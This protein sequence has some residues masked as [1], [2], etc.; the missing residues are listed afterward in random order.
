ML[1]IWQ[2]NQETLLF[3]KGLNLI[4]W[5]STKNSSQKAK[6]LKEKPKKKT[7][8]EWLIT[9]KNLMYVSF[10]RYKHMTR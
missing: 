4:H 10:N 6:S 2:N 5:W 9:A 3:T 8:M 7:T 1:L